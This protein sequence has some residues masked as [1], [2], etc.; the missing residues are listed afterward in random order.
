MAQA[1]GDPLCRDSEIP[2]ELMGIL[3]QGG[4][5]QSSSSCAPWLGEQ[6][7]LQI[8]LQGAKQTPAVP[9]TD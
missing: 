7:R 2:S 3:I 9:G 1:K 5:A 4:M 8:H 6:Q